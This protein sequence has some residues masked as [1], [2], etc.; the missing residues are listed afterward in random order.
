MRRALVGIALLGW[1]AVASAPTGIYSQG[2]SN[3]DVSFKVARERARESGF[4]DL[5]VDSLHGQIGRLAQELQKDTKIPTRIEPPADP[6]ARDLEIERRFLTDPHLI[7]RGVDSHGEPYLRLTLREGHSFSTDI[8]PVRYVLRVHCYLFPAPDGKGLNRVIFQFYRVNFSGSSYSREL[9]RVVHPAPADRARADEKLM[10]DPVEPLNNSELLLE[11]YEEPSSTKTVWE[12]WDDGVPMPDITGMVP[13]RQVFLNKPDKDGGT[14]EYDE[15]I[16]ILNGYK[17][18]LRHVD[19]V[20][21]ARVK[22][23][24]MDREVLI[25]RMLDFPS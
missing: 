3:D 2:V 10:T 4:A 23:L 20:L 19:R 16:R 24:R 18:L 9:R 17:R 8:Y 21:E 12:G 1:L 15:Q 14:L 7:V 25:E 5:D 13:V 11:L 6:A 22:S